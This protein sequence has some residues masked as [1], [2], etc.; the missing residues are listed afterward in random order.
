MTKEQ[1]SLSS[2]LIG[3]RCVDCRFISPA[4]EPDEENQCLV[5]GDRKEEIAQILQNG[6][7]HLRKPRSVELSGEQFF[8]EVYDNIKVA[9]GTSHDGPDQSLE[10]E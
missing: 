9:K 5:F 1:E 10:I 6:G 2:E 3:A 4:R 7:C 8:I